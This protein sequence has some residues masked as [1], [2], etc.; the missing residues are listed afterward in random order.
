LL[1]GLARALDRLGVGVGQGQDLAG[2]PVLHDD[3]DEAALVEGDLH[4]RGF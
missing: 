1:A 4:G 3:R 2:A